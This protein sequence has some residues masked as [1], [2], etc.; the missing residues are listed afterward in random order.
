[1]ITLPENFEALVAEQLATQP[2]QMAAEIRHNLGIPG[3]TKRD[4]NRVLYAFEN[5]GKAQRNEAWQ[6]TIIPARTAEA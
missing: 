3:L 2:N 5:Q 6:W 1:M 4:V